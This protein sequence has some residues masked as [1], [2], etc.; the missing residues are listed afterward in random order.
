M[1]AVLEQPRPEVFTPVTYYDKR[2]QN[3]T[4]PRWVWFPGDLIVPERKA[5]I[6]WLAVGGEET[7]SPCLQRYGRGFVPK[8]R[9]AILELGGEPIPMRHL[10]EL[11]SVAWQ[12]ISLDEQAVKNKFG[13]VPVFPGDGLRILK[14]YAMN[15]MRNGMDELTVLAGLE[16]PEC[17]NDEGTGILD[18]IEKA[19]FGDGV[20]KTL[21]AFEDQVR[22]AVV[23]DTRIDYGKMR[24]EQLKMCS[25]FRTW[26]ERKVAIDNG[27]L[28]LGTIPVRPTSSLPEGSLGGWAYTLSPLTNLLI[29]QLEL[30]RQDQPI[31]EMSNM[32]SKIL[33][34]QQQQAPSMS[35]ADLDLIEQR[36]E[37]RLAAARE[38]DA[39]R[40]AD[41][42]AKLATASI[43]PD[44]N[45]P[46]STYRC[47]CGKS[48]D[49][50]QGLGI[51]KSRH[52]ELRES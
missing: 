17:H 31:Q 16:W 29:E 6:S 11:Q 44:T 49:T 38:A 50:P 39:K 3:V 41:L 37:A 32:V 36:M 14:R 47:D 19:Q 40:I 24:E 43:V 42:E 48:F 35:A 26:A 25:D 45:P 27:L 8:G 4:A 33:A 2:K 10:G 15:P 12:G 9:A 7:P 46:Q 51:H 13:F 5:E 23:K 21:A 18:V 34:S 20:S 22:F 1:S 28:Q 52:C 30:K